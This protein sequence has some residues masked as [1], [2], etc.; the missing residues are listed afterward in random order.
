LNVRKAALCDSVNNQLLKALADVL[1]APICAL[2]NSSIRHGMVP[3][4]WKISRITPVPKCFPVLSVENNIRPIAVT[5][6][7]SKIAEFFISNFFNQHFE[8]YLDENQY[9][10][11]VGRS[12]TIALIRI[13]HVLFEACDNNKNFIRVLFVDFSKA[14]DLIDH[15]TLYK[16]FIEC[17]FP[18]HLSAWSLSFL[19][20]RKQFVKVGN[21]SSSTL[22]TT[23]GAPQGTR[24]GPNV[25][26]LISNDLRFD[27]PYVK[28]VDDLSLA[29]ISTD[30]NDCTLQEAVDQLGH[31]CRLN[32]MCLNTRKTKEMLIHFGKRCDKNA[33]SNIRIN[34]STL[35]RVVTF[36]LLGVHLSSDMSWSVHIDYIVSKAAKRFFVI[37]QLVRSGV[38]K[39]DIVLV[40]CAI[41]RSVL[42]YACQVWHCGLTKTQ[43]CEVENVQSRCLKIIYPALSYADALS[44]TGLERLD[45]RRE[46][47][48][49]ELFNEVKRPGHALNKFLSVYAVDSNKPLT[50]DSYPYK[51]PI[52]RTARLGRSFFAYCVN[53][54]M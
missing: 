5:C 3:E 6:P 39:T 1:A 19:E 53:K 51:M 37:C 54:R 31:W 40:Y 43:A 27:L 44:V 41:I 46:R 36:K 10:S 7:I 16:K 22:S 34:N 26:K 42:E 48:V 47:M 18:P 4:Q 12:T 45:D 25:F 2:I 15:G 29:S 24:A 50:R 14:F 28:Y 8:S 52:A 30:P 35:E 32:G 49:H 23:G 33:I 9:G 21:W 20:G 17:Q 38:D 13:C 11:T